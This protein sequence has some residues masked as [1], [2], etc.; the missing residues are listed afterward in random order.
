MVP[1]LTTALELTSGE[2]NTV[3]FNSGEFPHAGLYGDQIECEW[4]KEEDWLLDGTLIN[5]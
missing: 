2:S 3:S 1:G 4:Y 5:Q